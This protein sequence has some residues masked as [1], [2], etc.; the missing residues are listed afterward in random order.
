MTQATFFTPSYIGDLDR[1]VWLR[2]SLRAFFRGEAEHIMAVPYRDL[3]DFRR[4]LGHEPNLMLVSQEELVD[5]CFY[6]DRLHQLIARIAPGQLWRFNKHAGHPGW[7]IQQIVKLNSPSL[8][9]KEDAIIFLDSDLFFFKP[10]DFNTLGITHGRPLVRRRPET[11]SAQHPHHIV[12]A[13]EILFLP[14][15]GGTEHSYMAA[16]A[17][18]YADWVQQ[19]HRHLERLSGKPWQQ[20]LYEAGHISEYTLYGVYLEEVLKPVG[21]MIRDKPFNRI[22]WDRDSFLQ[23]KTAMRQPGFQADQYISLV[24]QS[25]IGIAT[26]EYEDLLRHIL[27]RVEVKN[28]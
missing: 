20:A 12:K 16:P 21:L 8:V 14:E 25:N 24:I 17:I 22:A 23:L 3:P 19:L 2:R 18:W 11:K 27:H 13:R 1:A 6:P 7:I 10:F 28:S 26:T 15:N 5:K 9:A 4:R